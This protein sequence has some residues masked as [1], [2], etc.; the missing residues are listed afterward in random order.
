MNEAGSWTEGV[1]YA[2][3]YYSVSFMKKTE[4]FFVPLNLIRVESS[5]IGGNIGGNLE[6]HF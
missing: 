4:N 1:C 5:C 6:S 3:Q 2:G